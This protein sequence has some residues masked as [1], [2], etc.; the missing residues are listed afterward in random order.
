MGFEW[1]ERNTEMPA[2][3]L[4]LEII[5]RRHA[6][7]FGKVPHGP[8]HRAKQ[9]EP[10]RTKDVQSLK[11]T[12]K[13]RTVERCIV[14][15]ELGDPAGSPI[16]AVPFDSCMTAKE[17]SKLS[18]CLDRLDGFTMPDGSGIL[19]LPQTRPSGR[20]L[21]KTQLDL[22]FFKLGKVACHG[23]C[24]ELNNG[25]TPAIQSTGLQVDEYES[26]I[27]GRFCHES[28]AYSNRDPAGPI[29]TPRNVTIDHSCRISPCVLLVPVTGC[30]GEDELVRLGNLLTSVSRL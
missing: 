22:E 18:S 10:G 15:D 14:G 3:G 7:R 26:L 6:G 2:E 16:L 30:A 28:V 5:R 19:I 13:K 11:P 23:D 12:V 29:G 27:H 8:L 20:M 17:S 24:R 9:V 1:M 25:M 21:M 4:K